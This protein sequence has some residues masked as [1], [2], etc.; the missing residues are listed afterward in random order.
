[1]SDRELIEMAKRAI[2]DDP[3]LAEGCDV[4]NSVMGALLTRPMGPA[5][6]RQYAEAAVRAAVAELAADGGRA[7]RAGPPPGTRKPNPGG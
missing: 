2:K 3:S 6:G 1:M 7:A 4:G 5:G